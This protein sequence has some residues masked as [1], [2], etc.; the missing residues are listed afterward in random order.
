[1]RLSNYLSV[2]CVI[3][4]LLCLLTALFVLYTAHGLY[5][6]GGHE[7]LHGDWLINNE[8]AWI[9]RGFFGSALIW[10]SDTTGSELLGLLVCLQATIALTVLAMLWRAA[11]HSGMSDPIILLLTNPVLF[12]SWFNVPAEFVFRKEMIVYLAFA[13]LLWSARRSAVRP[14]AIPAACLILAVGLLGHEAN[15]FLIPFFLVALWMARGTAVGNR[16]ELAASVFVVATGVGILIY[17]FLFMLVPDTSL[18]CAPLLERGLNTA[19]CDGAID[20]LSDDTADA[21]DAVVQMLNNASQF[22][23]PIAYFLALIPVL[24]ILFRAPNRLTLTSLMVGSG[25]LFLPLYLVAI[26]WGR[27]LSMHVYAVS[28]LVLIQAQTRRSVWLTQPLPRKVFLPLVLLNLVW[29]VDHIADTMKTGFVEV[30]PER[31]VMMY[32]WIFS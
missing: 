30:L 17:T 4:T 29:S 1:M 2:N 24:A 18:I 11:F 19:V 14:V 21:R 23:F 20:W 26:D 10:L 27:W 6:L 5:V 28:F 15:L 9:R 25:L 22:S 32:G 8:A 12:L 31:M 3:L 16:I 13:V 7:W